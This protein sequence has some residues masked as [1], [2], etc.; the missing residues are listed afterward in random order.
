MS[1]SVS[2]A[3]CFEPRAVLY[4][5]DNGE[6]DDMECQAPENTRT[7]TI[8][9]KEMVRVSLAVSRKSLIAVPVIMVALFFG[10]QLLYG[11]PDLL[12]SPEYWL[13]YLPL[14][15]LLVLL[16]AY[17]AILKRAKQCKALDSTFRIGF[18]DTVFFEECAYFTSILRWE[19]LQGWQ[20]LSEHILLYDGSHEYLVPKAPWSEAE[21][22]AMRACLR[23]KATPEKTL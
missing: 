20:E 17:R 21:C 15:M 13:P 4:R 7:V 6:V 23:A 3:S 8:T 11:G 19:Y 18:D 1:L 5:A 10:I 9:R 2:K 12:A 14:I 22:E 16:A